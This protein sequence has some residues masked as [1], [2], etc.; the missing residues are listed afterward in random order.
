MQILIFKFWT[1]SFSKVEQDLPLNQN[2]KQNTTRQKTTHCK[3]S[4]DVVW[5]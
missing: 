4:W 2:F 3:P 5:L 1:G